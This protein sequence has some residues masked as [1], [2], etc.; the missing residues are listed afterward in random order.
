[1]VAAMLVAG[2]VLRFALGISA[3]YRPSIA[4]S[5]LVRIEQVKRR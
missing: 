1:M 3:A 2:R 4:C 5:A